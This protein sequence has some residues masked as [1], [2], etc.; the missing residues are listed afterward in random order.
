[1]KERIVKTRTND[2][3]ECT[4]NL[5]TIENYRFLRLLQKTKK[6]ATFFVDAVEMLLGEDQEERLLDYLDENG[7]GVSIETM[8]EVL[9]EIMTNHDELKNC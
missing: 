9:N 3:F 5:D 8:G 2:G 7:R 1:M 6:D 4:I